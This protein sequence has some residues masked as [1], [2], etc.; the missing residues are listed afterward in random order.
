MEAWLAPALIAAILS[1]FVNVAGWFVTFRIGLRRDR[2][3]REEKVRDLQVARRAFDSADVSDETIAEIF[4]GEAVPFAPRKAEPFLF[5]AIVSEIHISPSEVIDPVVLY[6]GQYASIQAFATEMRTPEFM[7]LPTARR[8][9]MFAD[10]LAVGRQAL[11]FTDDAT[12][13]LENALEK[14]SR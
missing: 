14:R 6:Y 4:R 5:N 1:G 12:P 8:A 10:Y 3:L 7:S 2:M 9:A 11:D 13:A